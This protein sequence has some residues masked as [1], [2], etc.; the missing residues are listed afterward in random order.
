M[1]ALIVLWITLFI[2]V[3]TAP[4]TGGAEIGPALQGTY[5]V[6]VYMNSRDVASLS[7]TDE[8]KILAIGGS[9]IW[10][11]DTDGGIVWAHSIE[12]VT[13][14]E[15]KQT[16]SGDFIMAGRLIDGS[17]W[18][19]KIGGDGG[20]KWGKAYGQTIRGYISISLDS[21]DN[22]VVAADVAPRGVWLLKL[23]R[24]GCFVWSMTFPGLSS[25]SLA[26]DTYGN[27]LLAGVSE[28]SLV[29]LKLTGDGHLAWAKEYLPSQGSGHFVSL[30]K[31][32]LVDDS[33]GIVIGGTFVSG[34]Y[35]NASVLYIDHDGNVKWAKI[36]G[37]SS[38]VRINDLETGSQGEVILGG[39]VASFMHHPDGWI[40]ELTPGGEV[41]WS[42]LL[43]TEDSA[44]EILDVVVDSQSNVFAS[45]YKGVRGLIAKLPP[46]GCLDGCDVIRV[47][48]PSV[49]SIELESKSIMPAVSREAY[50]PVKV[51]YSIS[52][53]FP[54]VSRICEVTLS[55]KLEVSSEPTDAEV[56]IQGEYSSYSGTTPLSIEVPAGRYNVS[57]VK[58]E[59][60]KYK[61]TVSVEV[62]KTESI[63]VTLVPKFGYL[64]VTSVPVDGEVY[65]DNYFIGT[66]P[67]E[68]IKLSTGTHELR[69]KK[70]G[71]E[72]YAED[73]EIR[74]GETT[75]IHAVL[76]AK[77]GNLRVNST[78]PGL[79]V[80]LDG[81]Y[82]GT[83][84]IEG[85]KT[86]AGKHFLRVLRRG[87]EVYSGI[88]TIE[89]G[90]TTVVH[91]VFSGSSETSTGTS[92]ESETDSTTS[93]T[94][95]TS[96]PGGEIC[97]PG[98]LIWVLLLLA[99][100]RRGRS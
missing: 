47:R 73:F 93:S 53:W 5:W 19:A 56:V 70:D 94:G 82:I 57:V 11:M 55:G 54:E 90:G 46:Y 64:N 95:G 28:G 38:L 61:T 8:G 66:T 88:I 29:L 13:L 27:V 1:K 97:G 31:S 2:F 48:T 23:D 78:L 32:S 80:Y 50:I 12:N 42:V 96:P 44:E 34:F 21:K 71:Y 3:G 85:Y 99:L 30:A 43:G 87:E 6:D 100:V 45:G 10:M 75:K 59:Y 35:S 36:Y 40:M 67:L 49:S 25:P 18:I 68:E 52:L 33:G 26:V 89:P 4:L 41:V 65:V 86:S 69:V 17:L 63:S 81:S 14:G 84:P 74:P 92:T 98:S 37:T 9:T 91:V 79:E 72:E 24:D 15:L 51:Y 83:T 60:E 22:I 62:G 20:I 77:S 58:D 16:S 7:L 39:F 76:E